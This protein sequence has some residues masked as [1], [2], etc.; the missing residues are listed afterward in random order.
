MRFR[1]RRWRRYAI[2]R[3]ALVCEFRK[4]YA[5]ADGWVLAD[6]V[7]DPVDFSAW[8]SV[9]RMRGIDG[10]FYELPRRIE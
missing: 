7:V 1:S 4:A 10:N 2:A 8:A 3:A 5:F 9:G 6:P